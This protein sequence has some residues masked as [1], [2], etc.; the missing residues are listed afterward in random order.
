MFHEIKKYST[1]VASLAVP[2]KQQFIVTVN[3]HGQ[4]RF[5]NATPVPSGAKA[6]SIALRPV[7]SISWRLTS[8]KHHLGFSQGIPQ[9]KNGIQK[10]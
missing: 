10:E 5:T 4:T 1:H 8:E 6:A 7:A 9:C 2:S 3:C